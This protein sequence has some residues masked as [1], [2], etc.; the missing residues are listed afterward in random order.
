MKT[1]MLM[2]LALALAVL[3]AAAAADLLPEPGDAEAYRALLV[4][5]AGTAG[6]IR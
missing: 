1:S 3:P 4:R 5:R 6:Q 2:R